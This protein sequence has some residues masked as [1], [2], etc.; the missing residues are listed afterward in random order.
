ML[1]KIIIKEHKK[2]LTFDQFLE[3]KEIIKVENPSSVIALLNDA[4]LKKYLDKCILSHFIYL[5]SCSYKKKIIGYAIFAKKPSYL[6]TEHNNLKFK[7]FLFLLYNLKIITILN[8]IIK[9]FKVDEILISKENRIIIK[10]NLNLNMIAIKKKYQ[11]EGIGTFFLKKLLTNLNKKK[12][13]SII[14]LEAIDENA[15]LFYKKKF[16]FKILGT[17]IRFFKNLKVLFKKN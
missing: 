3:L 6:I 12:I 5:Y 2:K 10:N 4:Y 17:K 13:F 1:K 14:T 11:S 8:L 15:I 16:S 9:F 7:I